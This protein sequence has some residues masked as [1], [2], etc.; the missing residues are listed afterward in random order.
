MG[1]LNNLLTP[2]GMIPVK[3]REVGGMA[4]Q[5]VPSTTN[6][7]APENQPTSGGS[8]EEKIQRVRDPQLALSGSA[9]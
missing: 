3:V 9:G 8:Y 2:T 5:G 1:I 7:N 4:T 6:P